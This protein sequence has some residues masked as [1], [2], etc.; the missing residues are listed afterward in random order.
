MDTQRDGGSG[1]WE[2]AME[3]ASSEE[4]EYTGTEEEEEEVVVAAP[5]APSWVPATALEAKEKGNEHYKAQPYHD[6]ID[7]YTMA[8]RTPLPPPHPHAFN[9]PHR[10]IH[11][12]PPGCPACLFSYPL[13]ARPHAD[14]NVAL[15]NTKFEVVTIAALT[16]LFLFF[17]LPPFL[18]LSLVLLVAHHVP[19]TPSAE[20][21]PTNPA[22]LNNRAAANIM[23]RAFQ[24]GLDDALAAIELDDTDPKVRHSTP[25]RTRNTHTYTCTLFPADPLGYT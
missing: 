25:T 22:F 8:I 20:M 2:D 1:A 11:S 3:T 23:V 21:E 24:R 5:P 19:W 10:S 6:A 18:P 4:E 7:C 14:G 13:T 9:Q 12:S 17:N 16:S 15:R